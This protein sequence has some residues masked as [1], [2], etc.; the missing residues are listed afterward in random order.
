M[1]EIE[2]IENKTRR[3][4]V[5]VDDETIYAFYDKILDQSVVGG[6]TFEKWRRTAEKDDPK[7]L[8]MKR[9]DLMRHDAAG[10][11]AEWY[12]KIYRAA[13]IEM[14]LT[15][16]F[17]PGSVKDGVTLAVPIFALNQIDAVRT[18]WLVPGMLK[19]R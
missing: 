8:F 5:L 10:V 13:G 14:A 9:D 19:E 16:H 12:P 11:T 2:E 17:E 6:S 4:D 15:Y 18:E 1:R 7:I 3:P